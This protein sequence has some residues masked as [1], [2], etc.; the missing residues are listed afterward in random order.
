MSLVPWR[1][2]LDGDYTAPNGL[3]AH[4]CINEPAPGMVFWFYPEALG[5]TKSLSSE[6]ALCVP[7][8]TLEPLEVQMT[9]PILAIQ[10]GVISVDL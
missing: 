4:V 8:L 9:H 1:D 10:L 3:E 6:E 2:H 7:P 5:L